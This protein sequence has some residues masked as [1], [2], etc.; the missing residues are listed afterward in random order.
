MV[1]IWLFFIGNF[2]YFMPLI[3][4]VFSVIDFGDL[5]VYFC[6]KLFGISVLGGYV[7]FDKKSLFLHLSEKTAIKI[8]YSKIFKGR[9]NMLDFK[10]ASVLS[11][12]SSVI[13]YIGANGLL[14]YGLMLLCVINSALVPAIKSKKGYIRIKNDLTFSKKDIGRA[15]FLKITIATNLFSI[16][17]YLTGKIME[18]I[19]NAKRK[20]KHRKSS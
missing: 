6:I 8:D 19:K 1:G 16:N 2:F 20:I 11:V 4:S 9:K 15:C 12:K 7:T 5:K 14:N 3:F 18:K 17:T 10:T 13:T